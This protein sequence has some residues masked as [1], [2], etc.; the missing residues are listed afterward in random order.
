MKESIL[1]GWFY[2]LL[3][4][5]YVFIA[6]LAFLL[7]YILLPKKFARFKIQSLFP[8]QKDYVRE[9]GYSFFTFIVFALVGV[10]ISSKAVLPHTQIYSDL[11]EY[12]WGYFIFSVV[13]ALVIH[14]TY[15]YWTH[16]LMHHPRLFKLFH[17]THHK[18]TNPSPWAAFAFSPL[19]AVVEAS[20]IFVIAFLIPIHEY[21]IILF[22]FLMT[23]YNVYGHLGYEVYPHWLVNSRVG[24]WL[25]TS[26]NH[27]MHHKYFKGNYG[28]YFRFWD[29]WLHTTHPQYDQTIADLVRPVPEKPEIQQA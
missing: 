12:S 9:V 28:L 20:V 18:S 5:R 15:F 23:V 8:K 11:N 24:K 17:L 19:E 13:L 22:L 1:F 16:R 7:F 14:D 2:L 29:E 3:T 6:G 4:L 21:A 25:N 27:N 26:T 10:I